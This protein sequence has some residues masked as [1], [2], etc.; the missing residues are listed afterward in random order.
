MTAKNLETDVLRSSLTDNA[1]HYLILALPVGEYEVRASKTGF[2]DSTR[3][4]IQLNLNQEAT[5]DL[6]LQVSSVKS[7]VSVTE[8]AARLEPLGVQAVRSKLEGDGLVVPVL[9]APDE[10]QRVRA[11]SRAESPKPSA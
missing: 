9:P 2:Q 7:A 8:D 6:R 11:A 10:I 1:G 4:G 3:T 5:I